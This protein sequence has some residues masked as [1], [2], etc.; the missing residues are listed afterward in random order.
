[1][2]PAA[3]APL[4]KLYADFT[5]EPTDFHAVVREKK[6]IALR[7][8]LGS[9]VNRLTA[10]LAQIC[11][12]HRRQRD[13]T[14]HEMHEVLHEVIVALPVYRTYVR[15]KLGTGQRRRFRD[16]R[17]ICRSAQRLLDRI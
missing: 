7:E 5:N 12:Q 11:E 3:E 16:H 2:D 1:M 4:T 10:L 14:R 13:Y 6:A 15:A 17:E 8:L 9:D